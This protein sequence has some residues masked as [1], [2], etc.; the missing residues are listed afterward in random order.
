MGV[1]ES[2]V[3]VLNKNWV[4]VR[5]Q[6]LRDSMGKIFN[7]RAKFVN[8]DDY[9]IFDW[10]EWVDEFS[11]P[12]DKTHLVSFELIKS[13]TFSVRKPEVIICSKYNKVPRTD[14]KLTRRN[15]LIRDNF[16]CQ[17]T[18]KRVSSKDS[19]LDHI[20][21]RSKGGQ[22]TWDNLVICCS[23]TNLK[24]GDRTPK[25]A[26]LTLLREPRQPTWS[27]LF[28]FLNRRDR[29]ESWD[30]FIKADKRDNMESA[31]TGM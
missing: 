8:P 20:I 17:Y 16:T 3:L 24:K 21:P 30:K 12:N 27:P 5:I 6:S 25:E 28:S 18:G 11:I 22:N 19:T 2:P 23:S 14:I 7:E 31:G 1:L 9:S 26:G 15:L 29:P 4:P 10:E 13:K